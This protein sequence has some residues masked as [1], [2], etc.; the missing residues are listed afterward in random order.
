[1]PITV[2]FHAQRTNLDHEFFWDSTDPKILEVTEMVNELAAS[3]DI[4][5]TVDKS[6]DGLSSTSTFYLLSFDYW[7][8]F[9]GLIRYSSNSDALS[10]RDEYFNNAGHTLTF[11][12]IDQDTNQVLVDTQLIP[13]AF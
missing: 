4:V 3:S 13:P 7:L 5:H 8:A 12:I 10:K 11:K 1:M 9:V 2:M 6:E